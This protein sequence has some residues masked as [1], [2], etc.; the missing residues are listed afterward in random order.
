GFGIDLAYQRG[1]CPT[2]VSGDGSGQARL[3]MDVADP[4]GR[5]R[6]P[7][8]PRHRDELVGEQAPRQLEFAEDGNPT[9]ARRHH[10][11]SALRYA[12]AL[13]EHPRLAEDSYAVARRI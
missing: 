4:L 11:L 8:C 12:R 10:H 3:S 9:I 7:V 2:D 13:D 6:L 5:G 1:G